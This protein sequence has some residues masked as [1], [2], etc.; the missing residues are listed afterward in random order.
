VWSRG[1]NLSLRFVW[2]SGFTHTCIFG[3]LTLGPRRCQPSS[4]WDI[5]S[6][7]KGSGLPWFD[8]RLWGTKGSSKGLGATGKIGPQD[9]GT[10]YV[11][12]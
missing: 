1:R 8:I 7:S 3:F 11:K 5:W 10:Y 12:W 9:N 6:F 2:S 4:L